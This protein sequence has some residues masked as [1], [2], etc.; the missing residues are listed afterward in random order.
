MTNICRLNQEVHALIHFTIF[1]VAKNR[2]AGDLGNMPLKFNKECLSFSI[3]SKDKSSES[4][5]LEEEFNEDNS[6]FSDFDES[7]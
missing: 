1:Q 4:S 5:G 3:K 6:D 7:T 2:Y